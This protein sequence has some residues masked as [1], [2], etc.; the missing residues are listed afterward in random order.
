MILGMSV[1]TFTL[2]HVVISLVG[3]LA[4][5]F[6]LRGMIDNKPFDFWTPLFLATTVLTSVTGFM[7]HFTSFGPPEVVGAISLAVLA[8]AL[9]ALYACR[10]AGIWRAVYV[11]T[12]TLA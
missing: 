4:G 10:L 5:A 6:A 1:A 9:V 7:F 8:V 2:L 3:I 12:A 11:V